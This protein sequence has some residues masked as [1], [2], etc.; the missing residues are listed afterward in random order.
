MASPR[1]SSNKGEG[2][3]VLATLFA[4][5]VQRQQEQQQQQEPLVR[6]NWQNSNCQLKTA[7]NTQR[8]DKDSDKKDQDTHSVQ[9]LEAKREKLCQLLNLRPQSSSCMNSNTNSSSNS[10]PI[11]PST[12]S[13]ASTM[14]SL[15]ARASTES[16][17]AQ[18]HKQRLN[19]SS[20]G[21][22]DR[23]RTKLSY[24]TSDYDI[25]S[26]D[27]SR[28]KTSPLRTGGSKDSSK[29]SSSSSSATS[30]KSKAQGLD[31]ET[32]QKINVVSNGVSHN[33]NSS[34][35][36]NLETW[37]DEGGRSLDDRFYQE[38]ADSNENEG[39][40]ADDMFEY[41][42][43][44]HHIY[45]TYNERTLS[46]K[47]TTP[48]PKLA[49]KSSKSKSRLATKIA[50]AIEQNTNGRVTPESSDD[51]EL[52]EKE[53]MKRIQVKRRY[54]LLKNERQIQ[55]INDSQQ[56]TKGSNDLKNGAIII[57]GNSKGINKLSSSHYSNST[58]TP[59]TAS[60]SS[61]P[62]LNE[63]VRPITSSSRNI[64]RACLSTT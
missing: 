11:K 32:R 52:F 62:V 7:R 50:E 51:D 18:K 2:S 55:D 8:L 48:L 29:K 17:S 37:Y 63:S 42:E 5:A 27:I 54:E 6:E 4:A 45:T 61:S 14:A 40:K 16:S 43:R 38:L 44:M 58:E 25:S 12:R 26:N 33:I 20:D 47:Y 59:A 49:A 23:Q 19:D 57:N 34:Q 21:G 1:V 41:N 3:D 10:D 13:T 9:Q 31:R 36:R 46:D 28:T 56:L 24:T 30:L 64:L 39:W 60:L 53:R 22:S 35:L 15:F